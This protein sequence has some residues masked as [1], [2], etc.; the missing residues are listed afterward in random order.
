[1]PERPFRR[2]RHIKP[3]ALHG[4]EIVADGTGEAFWRDLYH[5]CMTIS[6]PGFFG[7]IGLAFVV[8]NAV[9]A[10]LYGLQANAVANLQ[11]DGL[12]GCFFFS[13]E[14]LATVGYGDMRPQTL[15]GHTIAT[16]EIFT[17]MM[18][19]ALITGVVFARFSRPR[20]RIVFTAHPIIRTY[21]G[22]PVLMVR[23]ANARLNMVSEA[24]AKLRLLRHETSP[25]AVQLVRIHDLKLER[26]QTPMLVLSWTLMH[27]I[28]ASSPLF[29]QTPDDLANGKVRL[30]LSLEGMDDNTSQTLRARKIYEHEDIRWNHG[31]R[32]LIHTDA[33]GRDH[34]DYRLIDDLIDLEAELDAEH[35][36]N[37]GGAVGHAP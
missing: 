21:N 28:D 31:Y 19:V 5:H 8:V 27:V 11:P 30:V 7:L 16:V 20:S 23:V 32:D 13:V 1:M 10:L 36:A 12:L 14:T 26:E 25:E 24:A 35:Q 22:Q 29:G 33:Q 3:A 34:V 9:F 37:Q 4:R 6:W 15:Y 2:P 18:S 17:G